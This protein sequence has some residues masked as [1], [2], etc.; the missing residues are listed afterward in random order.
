MYSIQ[1][2]FVLHRH[3]INYNYTEH[4]LRTNKNCPTKDPEQNGGQ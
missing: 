4:L 1:I 3:D 2:F